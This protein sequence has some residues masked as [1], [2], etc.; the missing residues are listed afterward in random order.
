[1]KQ[2]KPKQLKS[3]TKIKAAA[4]AKALQERLNELTPQQRISVL[5]NDMVMEA[6]RNG[7]SSFNVRGPIAEDS[8]KHLWGVY[9][10]LG[11]AKTEE[12]FQKW[13]ELQKEWGADA[14]DSG[15][16]PSTGE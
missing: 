1:M 4:A 3:E 11:D 5:A 16:A 12:V 9:V 15:S 10:T 2:K 14:V 7:I 8:G 13:E 6:L